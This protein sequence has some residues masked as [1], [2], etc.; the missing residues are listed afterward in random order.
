M[1]FLRPQINNFNLFKIHLFGQH[2][3]S[4]GNKSTKNIKRHTYYKFLKATIVFRHR[5]HGCEYF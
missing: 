3:L 2:Q 5:A 4:Y 1:R